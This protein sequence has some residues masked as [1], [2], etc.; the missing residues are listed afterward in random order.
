MKLT[1]YRVVRDIYAGYEVQKWR[2]WFPFWLQCGRTGVGI[3]THESLE[4]ALSF[5]DWHKRDNV[6]WKETK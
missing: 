5:I 4:K 1:K 6:V 3:N 2:V